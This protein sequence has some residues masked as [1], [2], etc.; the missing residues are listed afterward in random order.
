VE[1]VSSLGVKD[2]LE[3]IS[4]A[5]VFDLGVP[6]HVGMPHY[7]T[8][9]PFLYSLTKMHGEVVLAGGTSSAAEAIALGSH[10]GTHMDALCHFSRDGRFHDGSEA[11][12]CQTFEGGMTR[13]SIDSVPPVVRRGVLLDIAGVLDM[14][15]LPVDFTITPQHLEAAC[16][17][18]G[19][20]VNPGDVVLLRTGW[21]RYWQ[22]PA[23]YIANVHGPGPELEGARWLSERRVYAAGS[24]TVSFEKVPS[25][26]MAVH[27]HL[28]VESGIYIMEVLNLEQLAKEQVY[29]FVLVASPLKIRGGTGAPVRPV[30]IAV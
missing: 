5:R 20:V 16:L 30:A 9:P 13:L 28:L 6:Y 24:D 8:H 25:P 18:Q 4:G 17:H 14:D 3:R 7:P 11:R 23:K 26:S 19:V 27:V 29:E 2:L 1:L 12:T 10:V 15:V 21:M 22:E